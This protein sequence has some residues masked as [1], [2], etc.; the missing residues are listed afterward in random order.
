[1]RSFVLL[2][3]CILLTSFFVYGDAQ[4]AATDGLVCPVEDGI[5]TD[6]APLHL[7]NLEDENAPSHRI[8]RCQ[9]KVLSAEESKVSHEIPDYRDYVTTRDGQPVFD[10]ARSMQFWDRYP[11]ARPM[12]DTGASHGADIEDA[13]FQKLRAFVH[14][15]RREDELKKMFPGWTDAQIDMLYNELGIIYQDSV[16]TSY[17]VTH[18]ELG[19]DEVNPLARLFGVRTGNPGAVGLPLAASGLT[20]GAAAFAILWNPKMSE[21]TRTTLLTVIT[22]LH[23]LVVFNNQVLIAERGGSYLSTSGR[24]INPAFTILTLRF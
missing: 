2:L 5:H 9:N 13:G 21:G 3:N 22:V 4:G 14:S 24:V 23:G 7:V 10:L 19:L 1:M 17:F 11:Q 16:T 12:R 20:M 15:L 6:G 8:A 18:P